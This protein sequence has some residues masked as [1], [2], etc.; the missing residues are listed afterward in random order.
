MYTN[1]WQH[2]NHNKDGD[3]SKGN[4]DSCVIEKESV[5]CI[6]I[7]VFFMTV[8][9]CHTDM[10]V[11]CIKQKVLKV[12]LLHKTF[13][14]VF[15]DCTLSLH[16]ALFTTLKCAHALNKNH[17]CIVNKTKIACAYKFKLWYR[18]VMS[19]MTPRHYVVLTAIPKNM[20][21][22]SDVLGVVVFN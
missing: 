12:R 5:K 4:I 9:I 18:P 21:V 10:K 14:K 6:D 1:R 3:K 16:V 15:L 2:T 11:L 17:T 8:F 20:I 7:G 13:V 22:K 19:N